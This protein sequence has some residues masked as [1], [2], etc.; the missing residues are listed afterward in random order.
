MPV[1]DMFLK[2]SKGE[3]NLIIILIFFSNLCYAENNLN[4]RI[5]NYIN[6]LNFF[7][8]SFIQDDGLSLSEGFIY[9]GKERVRVEY[10]TPSKILIILGKDKAMYY[11]YE[12]DE[13]EFFN[14]RDTD[15]WFFY[16]ILLNPEFFRDS[17]IKIDEN[18]L[19]YSKDGQS[20]N[21]EFRINVFFE[22]NPFLLRKISLSINDNILNI[23]IFNHNYNETF[24]ESFF[25]LIN[26]SFFN[27]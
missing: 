2:N 17:K 21:G 19:I 12:L 26:P 14:P 16:E 6:N 8:G 5:I 24:N 27:Q 18:Y 11:N 10:E 23:S 9:L 3:F 20:E 4:E 15:A 7:S 13:D 25:K 22:N 1:K